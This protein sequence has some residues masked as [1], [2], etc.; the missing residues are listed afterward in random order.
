[1]RLTGDLESWV[2]RETDVYLKV[3]MVKKVAVDN[4]SVMAEAWVLLQ[5]GVGEIPA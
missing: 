1:M 2:T 5:V 3:T 4:L